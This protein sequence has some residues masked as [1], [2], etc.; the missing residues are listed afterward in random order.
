MKMKKVLENQGLFL[1]EKERFEAASRPLV[2][3]VVSL[4]AGRDT[5]FLLP[6]R[7]SLH[8]PPGALGLKALAG[9]RR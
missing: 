5:P 2:E 1:S 3:I 4:P 8:L 7:H 6:F 9:T